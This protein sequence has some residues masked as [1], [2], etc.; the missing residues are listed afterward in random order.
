MRNLSFA[1]VML[2]YLQG[3]RED[4]TREITLILFLRDQAK[5]ANPYRRVWNLKIV[6]HDYFR[7]PCGVYDARHIRTM[8][9]S[10]HHSVW[11]SAAVKCT[12]MRM[13]SEIAAVTWTAWSIR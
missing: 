8:V 6:G 12:T 7:R 4:K 10:R 13:V 11:A 5:L 1:A 9:R 2:T 3:G